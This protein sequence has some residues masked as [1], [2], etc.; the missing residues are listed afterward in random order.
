[1]LRPDLIR[2]VEEGA[3]EEALVAMEP[4]EVQELKRREGAVEVQVM[5]L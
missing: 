4:A 3:V 1:M 2:K 5:L